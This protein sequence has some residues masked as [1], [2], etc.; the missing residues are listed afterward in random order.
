MNCH[1][2][3]GK[4]NARKRFDEIR[5]IYHSFVGEPPNE[6]A[7]SAHDIKFIFGDL[8]FRINLDT[9]STCYLARQKSYPELLKND[10]L[11]SQYHQYNF[12]PP[13]EESPINFPPTYKFARGTCFYDLDSRP[14][15][16]CDRILW[17]SSSDV[18]CTK[19]DWVEAI[20][21]SD[22]KPVYGVYQLGIRKIAHNKPLP[23]PIQE[24]IPPP[25]EEF[26]MPIAVKVEAKP[27]LEPKIEVKQHLPVVPKSSDSFD[28]IGINGNF[29][30]N[31]QFIRF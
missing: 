5:T 16:W 28:M 23:P 1:L 14:P 22:H 31:T 12:L 24:Y 10:Q 29:Q 4:S 6:K 3:H 20:T 9:E 26:K 15:A 8:N 18:K 11:W 21:F 19:Y 7:A 30:K 25:I 27:K 17:E 13:L 2:A